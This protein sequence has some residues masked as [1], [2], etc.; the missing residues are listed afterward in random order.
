MEYLLRTCCSRSRQA[1][2]LILDHIREMQGDEE[3]LQRLARLLL[4]ES[5]SEE[6]ATKLVRPTL[7]KCKSNEDLKSLSYFSQH[8]TPPLEGTYFYMHVRKLE[9]TLLK[10]ILLSDSMESAGLIS[11]NYYLSEQEEE[12]LSLL[13]ETLG[14]VDE[15]HHAQLYIG[16]KSWFDVG[17]VS[18]SFFRMQEQIG[19]L[20]LGMFQRSL[21]EVVDLLK[22]LEGCRLGHLSLCGTDLHARMGDVSHILSS[23]TVLQL[24]ACRL[25]DDD[26][27]DLISIFPAGHGLVVLDLDDNAFSLDAVRALT[28]HLQGLLELRVLSLCN[29][30]L[31]A[32]LVRQVVSQDLSHLKETAKGDFRV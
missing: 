15:Q 13:E 10:G 20:G 27:K 23:F 21:D 8:V 4:W 32:E 26:V 22:A 1:A 12:E 31:D 7:V 9:L 16:A 25:V 17:R 6:L 30:G 3:E 29:I 14:V 19:G 28:R 2:G 24:R 18:H 11:V 5:G